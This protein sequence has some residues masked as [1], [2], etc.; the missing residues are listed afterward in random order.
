MLAAFLRLQRRGGFGALLTLALWGASPARCGRGAAAPVWL[1]CEYLSDPLGIDVLKPRFAWALDHS[2]RAERQT[3]YQILVSTTRDL[4]QRDQG[5][6]WDSK[7][8]A[9]DDSIQVVYQ[10]RPLKSGEAYY[11]KVRFWDS[12]DRA[13][14]Y[15]APAGFEMGLLSPREWEGAYGTQAKQG[16]SS[17]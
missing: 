11:W 13:S 2:E 14:A 9:S 8:T 10:G 4:L 3:A 5:D 12:K 7:K 6:R 16:I 1:R 15:S 17:P